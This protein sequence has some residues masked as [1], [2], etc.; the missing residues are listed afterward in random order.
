MI[1]AN[2]DIF[3]MSHDKSVSYFK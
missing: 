2:I 3:E 1:N